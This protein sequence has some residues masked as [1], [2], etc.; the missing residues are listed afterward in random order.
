MKHTFTLKAT[1]L[2]VFEDEINITQTLIA[3][4]AQTV[5][6]AVGCDTLKFKK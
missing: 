4:N 1:C 2:L 5:R 3:N 6:G